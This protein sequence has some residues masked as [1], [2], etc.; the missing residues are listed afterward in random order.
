[1]LPFYILNKLLAC[2]V[3]STLAVSKQPYDFQ[4]FRN[5]EQ[6]L[7]YTYFQTKQILIVST[8]WRL[9]STMGNKHMSWIIYYIKTHFQLHQCPKLLSNS[10]VQVKTYVTQNSNG[11]KWNNEL[12]KTEVHIKGITWTSASLPNNLTTPPHPKTNP[13]K[14]RTNYQYWPLLQSTNDLTKPKRKTRTFHSLYCK[15]VKFKRFRQYLIWLREQSSQS[16]ELVVANV[17]MLQEDLS[18]LFTRH[19]A[20][21]LLI[22]HKSATITT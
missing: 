14:C 8:H 4:C 1:M 12:S 6:Y 21:L 5:R 13:K 7:K 16:M 2:L 22:S 18:L 19:S 9:Y 10:K 3:F 20:F 11:S 17:G 15:N